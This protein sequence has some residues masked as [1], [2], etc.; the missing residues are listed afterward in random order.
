MSVGAQFSCNLCGT[1]EC[2]IL[3]KA[4]DVR[5]NLPEEFTL[6]CC[7]SC[8]LVCVH[9]QPSNETLS[10]HYPA[11]YYTHASPRPTL[12]DQFNS[13]LFQFLFFLFEGSKL[14]SG[15]IKKALQSVGSR[16]PHARHIVEINAL[17]Y[18]PGAGSTLLEVGFGRGDF[19]GFL[20]SRGYDCTGVENDPVCCENLQKQGH[21]AFCGEI[22]E[23]HLPENAFDFIRMRHTLEHIRRPAETVKK[24]FD[25][26]KPG[27]YIFVEVPN[28][29]GAYSEI[30]REDWA[31]LEVPRH[32]FHFNEATPSRLLKKAGYRIVRT[33]FDTQ[34][35]QLLTSIQYSLEN[36]KNPISE[37]RSIQRVS[38]SLHKLSSMLTSLGIGDNIIVIAQKPQ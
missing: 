25:I 34:P 23:L 38:S 5:F 15:V 32:L 3:I 9:P 13:T 14:H 11:E 24:L 16:F 17:E 37:I 21:T 19:L 31:Q 1:S 22:L 20:A 4:R 28:F 33:F 7:S 35:W 30:F 18:L 10:K 36:R 26:Q 6:V 27:G 8:G 29:D 12:K 2:I